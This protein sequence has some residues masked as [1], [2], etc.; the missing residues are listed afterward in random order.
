MS[1]V[2]ERLDVERKRGGGRDKQTWIGT[3]L[4]YDDGSVDV[5]CEGII[6]KGNVFDAENGGGAYAYPS[7]EA[8][9]ADGWIRP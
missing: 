4:V 1:A 7:L 9:E 2:V 6:V 5:Q 3:A 8:A